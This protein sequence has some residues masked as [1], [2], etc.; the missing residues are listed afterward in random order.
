MT[1]EVKHIRDILPNT[2]GDKIGYWT[3][4]NGAC[5]SISKVP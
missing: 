5:I 1:K 3:K 4:D 2:T